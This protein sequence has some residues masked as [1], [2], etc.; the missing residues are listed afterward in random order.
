MKIMMYWIAPFI[1]GL[2]LSTMT[3]N[4]DESVQHKKEKTANHLTKATITDPWNQLRD[5]SKDP[6][7]EPGPFYPHRLINMFSPGVLTFFQLPVA[8]TPEDLKAGKVDVAIIGAPMDM[9]FGMRGAGKGPIAMRASMAFMPGGEL[10]HMHVGIAWKRELVA[11][12]YGNA[13]IDVLSTEH[14]MPSVRKLVREIAES[15]AIPVV[16]GGD[17]SLEYPNVAGVSDVYGKKN[18]GVIHFDAHYDA[19]HPSEMGGHLISHGQPIRRLIEDEH[20]LGKNYIQVGLRGYWP[21]EEGFRWM[22]ENKFRYHTMAEIERDG[23]DKVMERVIAE[24]NDGPE[25]LYVSFDIDVLDPAYTPGTGTPENGGLTPREVFPLVRSLCTE[26]NIVGF[27]LVELNPLADPGYTT[28]LNANRIVQE[29]LT[30]IAMR[31]KGITDG[32]YLNPLTSD[33]ARSDP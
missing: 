7:R 20:I 6:K 4:A 15:G 33:D 14:S 11:V 32:K 10:P 18:V 25:Y 24:A 29:C 28:I 13:P 22:R 26:K 30:G 5:T 9:S 3:A 19:G 21:G 27:D 12:D 8:L 1:F 31:K 2:S 16:I 23:W 17:H